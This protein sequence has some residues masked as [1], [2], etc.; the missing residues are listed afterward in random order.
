M[1]KHLLERCQRLH[2]SEVQDAIPSKATSAVLELNTQEVAVIGRP[3]NLRNGYRYCFLCP[4]CDK[5][6]ES[7]YAVDLGS[8]Q[9]RL[10]I[11]AV[12]A[13]TRKIRVESGHYEHEKTIAG[14]A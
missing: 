1:P 4:K 8:W 14:C 10:C 3:T 2:I 6:Y 5:P 7:L 11:G 12:Y 13:S 9:C